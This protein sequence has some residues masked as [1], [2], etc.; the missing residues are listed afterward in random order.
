MIL[1]GSTGDQAGDE[2][3]QAALLSTLDAKLEP[4]RRNMVAHS[5]RRPAQPQSRCSIS[6][7][8]TAVC[9][10]AVR[11]NALIPQ[12]IITADESGC[13]SW[14][15]FVQSY[16]NQ[17]APAV[18]CLVKASVVWKQQVRVRTRSLHWVSRTGDADMSSHLF[19]FW[20]SMSM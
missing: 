13:E 3:L 19:A 6:I 10:C 18:K 2:S 8:T 1:E 7:L 16:P 9:V 15:Q 12:M 11:C 5:S 4:I 17:T 20:R 14:E